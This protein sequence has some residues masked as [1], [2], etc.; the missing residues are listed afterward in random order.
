MNKKNYN[1]I[2]N[3]I[4]D[5]IK[6]D[7]TCPSLLLHSC[8]APCSSA[9][10]KKLSPF[11]NITIFYYNPNISLKDEYEKRKNEEINFIKELNKSKVFKNA[12]DIKFLDCDYNNKDF[13]NAVKGYENELEG[14]KRCKICYKLRLEETA[15]Q[16]KQNGFE[17]FST[18]LSVSPYKDSEALNDIGKEL[19]EK[20]DINYLFSDFKKENGYKNSIELSKEYGLYRQDY[21][22]CVFSLK[23]REERIL[24]RTNCI[25]K[26]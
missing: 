4:I 20:Y 9:V 5:K 16:A 19:S 25:K 11:F 10:L 15:K 8:C 17:F 13:F 12:H 24:Q 23:E 2:L 7:G 6:E 21:C 26:L 14:G 1:D 3:S 18:T 22:G